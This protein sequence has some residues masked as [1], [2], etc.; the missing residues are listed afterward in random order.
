MCRIERGEQRLAALQAD[1]EAAEAEGAEAVARGRRDAAAAREQLEA[2]QE[3][4]TT[5]DSMRGTLQQ[6]LELTQEQLCTERTRTSELE[7][8]PLRPLLSCAPPRPQFGVMGYGDAPPIPRCVPR[9]V[10]RMATQRSPGCAVPVEVAMQWNSPVASRWQ[11]RGD[12]FC[13]HAFAGDLCVGVLSPRVTTPCHRQCCSDPVDRQ[14][15]R[16]VEVTQAST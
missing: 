9:G 5:L 7:V 6:Q 4:Y 1:A 11:L 10:P 12:V 8:R 13:R 14:K 16:P 2:L 15:H 3:A